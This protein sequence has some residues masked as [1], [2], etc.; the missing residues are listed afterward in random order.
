ME[1]DRIRDYLLSLSSDKKGLLS[2]LRGYAL[3]NEVP[4]IRRET[5]ELL[6]S[7]IVLK[8]PGSILEIGTAIGYSAIL[9]AGRTKAP[10]VTIESY[11]KRILEA[12]RNFDRAGLSEQISLV[13]G[14]AGAFLSLL[15][16]RQRTGDS[17]SGVTGEERKA[18]GADMSFTE[19]KQELILLMK[20]AGLSGS[21]GKAVSV[22][23]G[24]F[25]LIFLDAAKGQYIN[26]LPY[27]KQLMNKGGLLFSD[28]VLQDYTVMESRYTVERRERTTHKRMREFLYAI[29]HDSE[30]VSSVIPIGDGVSISVRL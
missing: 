11:E 6:E 25:D 20:E 14:D 12:E 21:L 1:Q 18:S 29:K 26:W 7:L 24:G 2:E 28:N 9:M 15:T 30:L 16:D 17:F 10:I 13:K 22:A 8:T 23:E 4:I 3:E 27:I 5:E 19:E